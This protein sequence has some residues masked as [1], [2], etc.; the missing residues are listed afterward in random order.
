MCTSSYVWLCKQPDQSHA[1]SLFGVCCYDR[2]PDHPKLVALWP[3]PT[4]NTVSL[5]GGLVN[6]N[7]D[8]I[9]IDCVLNVFMHLFFCQS[10]WMLMSRSTAPCLEKLTNQRRPGSSPETWNV[11]FKLIRNAWFIWHTIWQS[12]KF[13]KMTLFEVGLLKCRVF[14]RFWGWLQVSWT[15]SFTE[16]CETA[17]ATALLLS[18]NGNTREYFNLCSLP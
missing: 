4:S 7:S 8:L 9:F 15:H 13:Q 12:K 18:F 16:I 10:G 17:A 11:S 14:M 2:S 3:H 5:V 6:A 1:D